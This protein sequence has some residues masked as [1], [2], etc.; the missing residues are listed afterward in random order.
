[1]LGQLAVD[2]LRSC[3]FLPASSGSVSAGDVERPQ[4]L[5]RVCDLYD[6]DVTTLRNLLKEDAFPSHEFCS[7]HLLTK[8]RELGLQTTLTLD[9]TTI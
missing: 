6:P 9:G 4:A 1:L 8:L 2:F 5:R 7:G 3:A